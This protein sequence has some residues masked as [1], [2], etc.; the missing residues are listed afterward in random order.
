MASK[1]YNNVVSIPVRKSVSNLI[2]IFLNDKQLNSENTMENYKINIEQFF[3]FMRKKSI[4]LLEEKDLYFEHL[5][6]IHY[7][8]S[9]LKGDVTGKKLNPTSV[10]SK[11]S[12]IRSLFQTLAIHNPNIRAEIF[13]VDKVKGESDSYGVPTYDEAMQMIELSKE[14]KDGNEKSIMIELAIFT[15]IRLEALCAI[16]W[17]NIKRDKECWIV[18]A[19]DKGKKL[20]KKPIDNS[21]YERLLTLKG[22]YGEN[23]FGLS[24]RTYQRAVEQVV[25]KMGIED[26]RNITF[27]SLKKVAINWELDETGNVIMACI[28]GN[29]SNLNTMYNSYV[30]KKKDYSQ[31]TGMRMR[32]DKDLSELE[33]L[34]KEQLLELIKNSS[35]STQN[36][37]VLKARGI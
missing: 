33:S 8:T 2:N 1:A 12:S 23:V 13:N 22:M 6:I 32:Q 21:L 37:L 30:Q 31:M 16:K 19:I 9:L 36:E 10:N 27:H 5:D 25:A 7:K 3:R 26:G 29:H 11:I 24:S 15:S 20:D 34:S 14:L 4:E 35:Y 28:Q 17:S 18:E